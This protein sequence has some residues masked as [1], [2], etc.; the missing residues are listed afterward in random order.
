M[1]RRHAAWQHFEHADWPAARDAFA[2]LLEQ[3]PGDPEALDGLGQ[4]PHRGRRR[5]SRRPSMPS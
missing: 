1:E 3:D 5:R 2:A 4:S